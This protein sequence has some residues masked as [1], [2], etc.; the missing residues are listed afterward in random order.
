LVYGVILELTIIFMPFGRSDAIRRSAYRWFG[1]G[2]ELIIALFS[3]TVA[4]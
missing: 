4:G 2:V 1:V 3:L